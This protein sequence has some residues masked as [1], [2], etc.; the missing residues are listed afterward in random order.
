MSLPLDFRVGELVTA[1][2]P[3]KDVFFLRHGFGIIVQI[4]E[5]NKGYKVYEVE[6]MKSR[7]TYR[8]GKD[9]LKHHE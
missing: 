9:G 4:L 8:F 2:L 7:E 5:N 1:A 3:Q 6:F